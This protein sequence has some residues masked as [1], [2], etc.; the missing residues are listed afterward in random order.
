[1]SE[2]LVTIS[3][4]YLAALEYDSHVYECLLAC[5]VGDW[6]GYE[7]AHEMYKEEC[8]DES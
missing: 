8:V 5:G 6:E 1:M 3:R 7:A 2:V 4:D